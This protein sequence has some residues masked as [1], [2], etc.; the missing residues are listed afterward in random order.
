MRTDHR[1]HRLFV[2]ASLHAGADVVLSPEQSHYLDRVMRAKTGDVV[3]WRLTT[4][5]RV[6][7]YNGVETTEIMLARSTDRCLL[8]VFDDHQVF[9][10]HINLLNFGVQYLRGTGVKFVIVSILPILENFFYEY[11]VEY[12][13]YPEYCYTPGCQLDLGTD[14]VHVGPLPGMPLLSLPICKHR[15]STL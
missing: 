3:I 15:G 14:Q 13:K 5:H 6:S 4:P 10:N 9:F 1:A 8:E 12:S 11:L 7:Q 2:E